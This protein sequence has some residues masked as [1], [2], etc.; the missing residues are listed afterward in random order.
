[1]TA[2]AARLGSSPLTFD[3]SAMAQVKTPAPDAAALTAAWEKLRTR[4]AT[5]EVGFYD[6]PTQEELAQSE[7]SVTLA[8]TL[9]QRGHFTDC[10][11]LG[12]GGSALGPITLL[13]ALPERTRSGVRFHF[14]DNPDPREWRATLAKLNPS[15]TLVCAI[16][17]SGTTFETVA[18]IL[19]ALEWL[20]R[21]RLA[22]Q[23]VAI[24]DPHKGDLGPL[25]RA[26][27]ASTLSIA[28]S[29]GGR[30][31]VF[32]PVGLFPAAFAGLSVKDFLLGARQVRDYCEKHALDRNPL[33]ILAGEL[34]RHEAERNIH[35]C[36]PYSSR[37]RMVGDWFVQLWG[38]SLGK[39]GKGFTPLAA[40]GATD[41]HSLLQLL[42]DGPDD[43]I[44]LFLTVDQIDDPVKIPK[45]STLL[46]QAAHPYAAFALLEG[47][48]FQGLLETEYQ[49][50]AR[51]L[52][53]ANRPHF[54]IRLDQLDERNMGALFFAMSV[55][56]AM[57]GTLWGVDPF[58][59]PGVEE[60]KI[61][62]RESLSQKP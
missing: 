26:L 48:T 15:T 8:E 21:D 23:F 47:H 17:K 38:E 11:C 24:T 43:K 14:L 20:G 49:A 46:N 45:L 12:I 40:L 58:D 32:S 16:A 6:A 50:I 33:M 44:T 51:V 56:T 39:D 55:L 22:N 1:M 18:Q 25:A 3:W 54:T 53:R 30:F 4:F 41:Q 34:L 19:C 9:L 7:A 59:Q 29:I 62:I 27:G 5:N 60:G 61:Y 35:V 13:Q 37:L 2:T 36:M 28:P 52:T 57:T 42:R 10:L 31:S